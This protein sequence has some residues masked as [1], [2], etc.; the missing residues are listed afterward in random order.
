MAGGVVMRSAGKA[1]GGP[2]MFWSFGAAPTDGNFAISA[3]VYVLADDVGGVLTPRTEHPYLIDGIPGDPRYSPIR[4]IIY[5]PVTAIYAGELLTSVEALEEAIERGLVGEPMPAGTWRNL[6]VVPPGT[7]LE[8][9]G[10][11]APMDALEVYGRGHRISVFPLGGALGIQPLRN[12]GIPMGQESRLLS[13][14]ATGTPPVKTTTLDAQPVFQYGIPLAPPTTAF[15]YTPLVTEVDVRL[16]NGID[17]T[18]IA[19]DAS[20]FRRT[21]SGAISGYY[22]DNVE[23]YLLT[24]IVSNK[25][26]QFAEGAP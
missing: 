18:T 12:N 9:G 14:V 3:P 13:G 22:T 21:T 26:I 4:R 15:N 25:Q 5:L 11:A 6:P 19:S 16:A 2:V 10:V 23:S 17:P 7:R 8:L 20:L 24:S 1:S